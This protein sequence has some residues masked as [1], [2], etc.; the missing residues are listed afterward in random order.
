MHHLYPCL[1]RCRRTPVLAQFSCRRA[2]TGLALSCACPPSPRCGTESNAGRRS[3]FLS[4]Y[5]QHSSS[6]HKWNKAV[7][8]VTHNVRPA[9][10]RFPITSSM[11]TQCKTSRKLLDLSI[12]SPLSSSFLLR[13]PRNCWHIMLYPKTLTLFLGDA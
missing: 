12:S 2:R 10:F 4:Q 13:R 1:H 5:L 6:D 8:R 7:K 11:T 9:F 3:S